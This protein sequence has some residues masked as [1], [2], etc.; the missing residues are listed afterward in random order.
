LLRANNDLEISAKIFE[1]VLDSQFKNKH[2]F[3]AVRGTNHGEDKCKGS[4]LFSP[5]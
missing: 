2:I 5:L 3:F 1:K 4:R